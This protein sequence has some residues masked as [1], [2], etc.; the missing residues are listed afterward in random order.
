MEEDIAQVPK[1]IGPYVF[2]KLLG[3]GAFA[4]VYS[5]QH[6]ITETRVAIKVIPKH[7]LQRPGEFELLQREV[8]IMKVVDYPFISAF[9]EALD[10]PDNFY[11]V[12]ELAENGSLLDLI[13]KDG[14]LPEG[15]AKRMFFQLVL[16]LEYLHKVKKIVHR[17]L[18]AENILLDRNN[19][20]RVVDFGLSKAFEEGK[21]YLETQCGSPA[22]VSP[23]IIKEQPYTSASDIWSAGVLLYAMV[24]GSLPFNS[25]HD[26]LGDLLRKIL[27][28]NV[29]LPESLS[30]D[31]RDLL[32]KMLIK[33]P[34]KRIRLEE[35]KDH[36][37]LQEFKGLE[38]ADPAGPWIK[39][40]KLMEIDAVDLPIANL[41][42]GLKYDTSSLLS[43][44]KKMVLNPTTAAYKMLRRERAIDELKA[45]ND[46]LGAK[47]VVKK[48]S[49]R[50]AV[51]KKRS[52]G[53]QMRVRE[54]PHAKKSDK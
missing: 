6:K 48:T 3:C 19:N 53:V 51:A 20:I 30:R 15:L 46:V 45:W 18:K 28:E 22:Y 49:S 24:L 36:A 25:D 50:G 12:I 14:G 32:K 54:N 42:K 34:R 1:E 52:S 37:W 17:D 13:N 35:V 7:K 5:A 27:E 21:P 41:M 16:S 10:D 29:E 40:F 33:D 2:E 47:P 39:S 9:Y 4:S 23:E 31:L 26:N 38:A 11:L 8:S 44:L 43:D